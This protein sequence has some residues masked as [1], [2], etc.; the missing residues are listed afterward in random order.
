[1]KKLYFITLL[2]LMYA[3]HQQTLKEKLTAIELNS[4]KSNP[5]IEN[6]QIDSM[7]IEDLHYNLGSIKDYYKYLNQ[8][9]SSIAGRIE[10]NVKNPHPGMASDTSQQT[11]DSIQF[12]KGEEDF[13]NDIAQSADTSVKIYSLRYKI[14]FIKEKSNHIS[15]H[16]IGFV[17]Q[18][19]F[20]NIYINID[21]IYRMQIKK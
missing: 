5:H 19:D 20:N 10:N 13:I 12:Y 11:K 8:R 6:E 18:K 17:Y 21:S 4:W 7:K 9:A 16:S 14:S 1:M 15:L 2:S 3:C